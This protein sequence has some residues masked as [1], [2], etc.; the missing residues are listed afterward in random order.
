MPDTANLHLETPI[1]LG[2]Y[3][4]LKELQQDQESLDMLMKAIEC[5]PIQTGITVTDMH[6]R[7]LYVNA[8][9]AA[10]HGYR[11]AELLGEDADLFSQPGDAV[12][13]R[14]LALAGTSITNLECQNVK[15]SGARFPVQIN[16]TPLRNARG[17]CIAVVTAC[18]D[19]TGLKASERQIEQLSYYDPTSGLPNR[20]LFLT[21]LEKALDL[22]R[23]N[24]RGVAVFFLDL[25]NFK[26]LL[27][28]RGHVFGDQLLKEVGRRLTVHL[29]EV[30]GLGHLGT[31]QFLV[32]LPTTGEEDAATEAGKLQA[33]F[34]TPFTID[35]VE[36]ASSASIGVALY[37]DDGL[38]VDDMLRCSD[39]AM[40]HAKQ[41]GKGNCQFYSH[42]INSR[43]MR[44]VAL[45]NGI[46]QG[47]SLGEFSLHYQPQWDLKSGRLVGVE[48]LLRWESAQFGTVTPDEFIPIAEMSGLIMDLGEMVLTAACLQAKEWAESLG[49]LKVAVNISGRQFG[50][51]DFLSSVARIVEKT[52]VRP[53]CLELEFTE[54]VIMAKASR[55]IESLRA[56]KEMGMQ[57]AIDDF[58]TG[59]SS[60]SYLKHFPIDVIKIDRSFIGESLADG[61]DA[62][63]VEAIISMGHSMKL[64]VVAE[65][66]ESP[67]QL[68]FLKEL[69]CDGAQGFFLAPPMTSGELRKRV[70]VDRR[71]NG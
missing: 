56:L 17:R 9:Q 26:Y 19:I 39:S 12:I 22:A 48:A 24:G 23:R 53:S 16:S 5:L 49:G 30:H 28:T 32:M 63:I 33:L 65:G 43:R 18:E 46:R 71:A 44:R 4:H 35:G 38:L 13:F 69:G 51:P 41:E 27:D 54:S 37:P 58:G 70:E 64:K 1:M 50:H 60:L 29:R 14:Q 7:I 40:S 8:V 47:L 68:Q 11:P 10:M 25:D 15:K 36:I 45:E 20:A 67:E 31:D 61:D 2:A 3:E 59:Y 52:G 21:R 55:N 62:A 34:S 42:E 6:G 66:V 57:L